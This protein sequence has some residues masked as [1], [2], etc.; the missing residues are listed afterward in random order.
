MNAFYSVE[1]AQFCKGNGIYFKLSSIAY[2]GVF[3][4]GKKLKSKV[5]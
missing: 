4:C 5:P 1:T 3:E 2:S